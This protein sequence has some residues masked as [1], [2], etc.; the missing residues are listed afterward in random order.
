[1]DWKTL[2]VE[3]EG[4]VVR[5]WLNRPE[6]RNAL[7]QTALQELTEAFQA[8]RTDFEVKVVV[9]GG[10]GPTFCAGADLRNAPGLPRMTTV[11][12]VSAREQ[13]WL[14]ELGARALDAIENLDAITIAR[15]QGHAVGGG[16]LLA[17]ACDFRIAAE[18]TSFW[19]PE[20]E[21]G[22]LL[23]WRGVP[24]LIR[25]IGFARARQMVVLSEHF[26]TVQADNCG[27]LNEKVPLGELDSA[28]SA[29]VARLIQTPELA[30]LISKA[31]FRA[32]AARSVIGNCSE[33][34][35]EL[36]IRTLSSETARA[37][38]RSK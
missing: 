34:E 23:D 20:V 38:F 9:L 1:M 3:K 31:Q 13:R 2:I 18:G 24:R 6:C 22:T 14:G 4:P 37:G 5:V 28:I 8:L 30:L 32:Y 17:L 15:I 19:F 27:L 16:V 10:K 7:D 26:D 21:F 33:F 11:S 36:L 35:A 12:G 25:E 29:Y